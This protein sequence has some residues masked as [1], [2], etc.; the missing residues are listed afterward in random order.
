MKYLGEAEIQAIAPYSD[1]QFQQALKRVLEH[2]GFASMAHTY[3]PGI[4][5]PQLRAKAEKM[6]TIYDF[7][8][9]F[10]NELIL[11]LQKQTTSGVTLAGG[12]TRPK[13]RSYLYFSNHRDI[14]LDPAIFTRAIFGDGF[15]TPQICLGDNLLTNPLVIDLVKMNKAI[16]V[17]RNLAAR[18]LLHWS[19]SLSQWIRLQ[20]TE[21]KDS[22]WIAQREGRAKDGN[23]ETQPSVLKMLTLSG[24]GDFIDRLL[25]L[26][27]IPVAI[28]YEYDPSDLEKARELSIVERHGK[29]QK[30]TGEDLMAMTRGIHSFKGGIHIQLGEEISTLLE[31]ARAKANK[32]EQARSV[33]AYLDQCIQS[34]YRNWPSNFI[35]YDRFH[36]SDRFKNSYSKE[37]EEEFM[38][39]M[40]GRLKELDSSDDTET[41]REYFLSM[42][43]R[44]VAN[45]LRIKP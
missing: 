26:H 11:M 29:Y 10:I 6:K 7:Q 8:S 25:E 23:D 20:I 17:K 42:Y 15:R 39:R 34:Q 18:E 24:T 5:P 32:N 45:Q 30:A 9:G 40:E 35:A 44:P 2:P 12:E 31:K 3:F 4:S 41:I 21:D 38:E 33:A 28:S 37:K 22:V 27:I 1:L 16:T 19:H 43:A 36:Q 13:D 14:I